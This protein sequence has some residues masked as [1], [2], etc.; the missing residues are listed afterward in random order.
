[1]DFAVAA[2]PATSSNDFRLIEV[3][4]VETTA[5]RGFAKPIGKCLDLVTYQ[6][7]NDVA[8]MRADGQPRQRW[9]I[10]DP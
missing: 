4:C 3:S 1:M 6:N 8:I 2:T 9:P 7:M 10:F 5:P